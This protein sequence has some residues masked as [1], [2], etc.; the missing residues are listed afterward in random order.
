MSS[1]KSP[2]LHCFAVAVL[3][4][5]VTCPDSTAQ[6]KVRINGTEVTDNAD[7]TVSP[8]LPNVLSLHLDSREKN[9]T[10]VMAILRKVLPD[11]TVRQQEGHLSSGDVHEFVLGPMTA[12]PQFVFEAGTVFRVGY[13]IEL[14]V[15]EENKRV[16]WHKQWSQGLGTEPVP[17]RIGPRRLAPQMLAGPERFVAGGIAVCYSIPSSRWKRRSVC[18]WMMPS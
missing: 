2:R 18:V 7:L 12:P 1:I 15:K 16:L 8:G 11:G 9:L 10:G 3:L 4:I 17:W 5:S 6:C 13:R 14:V